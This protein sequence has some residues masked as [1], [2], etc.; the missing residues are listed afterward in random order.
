MQF[1]KL[2]VF[3]TSRAIRNYVNKHCSNGFLPHLLTI[4]DFFKKAIHVN[5]LKFIDEEHRLLLLKEST[6][7]KNFS[8]LGISNQFNDFIKQSDYIFRFFNEISAEQVKIE[9]IKTA[10]TYEFYEEHLEILNQIL[11]N[12]KS[13]LERYFYVDQVNIQEHYSINEDYVKQFSQIEIYFEGYFTNFEYQIIK[14]CAQHTKLL[15]HFNA[16]EFNKK[17]YDKFK[18]LGF[19]LEEGYDYTLNFSDKQIQK[20]ESVQKTEQHITIEGFR[21]RINQIAYIKHQVS[22]LVHK[23]ILTSDIVIVVPDESFVQ[24]MQEFDDEAYF[25][26]AMGKSI[27]SSDLYI[28]MKALYDYLNENEIQ[29]SEYIHYLNRFDKQTEEYLTNEFKKELNHENFDMLLEWIKKDETKEELLEKFDEVIYKL[30]KLLFSYEEKLTLKEAYRF[31]IQRVQEITLDD[32]NSGP[33][34]VMGLLETRGITFKAVIIVD[35]NEESV[36]KKSVKDK[37]LSSSIKK[38]AKL[39]TLKDR[40]NLQKFYYTQLCKEADFVKVAYVK[41]ETAQISRFAKTLFRVNISDITSDEKYKEI[42]FS[43]K[44]FRHFNGE[45]KLNMDLSKKKWSATSLKSYLQCKRKYYLKYIANINEHH[46]SVK[47][48]GFELGSIIHKI[49]EE[50]YNQYTQID[51]TIDD[52]ILSSEITKYQNQNPFLTLELEVWKFYLKVFI[53]KE[54]L[55]FN[56]PKE[57][58]YTEKKFNVMHCGINLIGSI[59]R[60]DFN[61]KS[62]HYAIIDYKTSSNL[63]VDSLKN[64]EKSVEFQLEFYYIALKELLQTNELHATPYY[65]DLKNQELIEESALDEKLMLLET[66]LNDLHTSEVNFIKCEDKALCVYCP[67]TQIC[68]RD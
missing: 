39:P 62:N 7:I 34:T 36:P 43:Q 17:A 29:Q 68:N 63:K 2:L 65:Y 60:V 31:L 23:G 51:A 8:K 4:Q 58:L 14:E 45:I 52:E 57:V 61:K 16:N 42:L 21:S 48:Q 15:I 26:Y 40:E 50:F 55:L 27:K 12:Y 66:V 6:N 49:L 22:E 32:V 53:Q 33:V 37:F 54:K 1:K 35:F 20:Q 19:E 44:R 25:N 30:K 9:E 59:D 5:N 64:Y 67:Y 41:N 24:I 56:E 3:P 13:L 38:Y 10:D 11:H 47:P 18:D 46:F 28:S